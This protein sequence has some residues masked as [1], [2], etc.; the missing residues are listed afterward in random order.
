MR[1]KSTHAS[2]TGKA[3]TDRGECGQDYS[4][5]GTAPDRGALNFLSGL[6]PTVRA[7]RPTAGGGRRSRATTLYGL[8]TGSPRR[9]ERPLPHHR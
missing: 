3:H 1:W 9:G 2:V 6:R 7:A 4:R 5:A 8:I